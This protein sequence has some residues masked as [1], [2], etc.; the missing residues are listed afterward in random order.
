MTKQRT[1][2]A[3]IV[4][5]DVNFLLKIFDLDGG[6]IHDIHM[7]DDYLPHKTIYMVI[8]HPDLPEVNEVETLH[9]A[10]QTTYGENGVPIKIERVDPPKQNN[11][12]IKI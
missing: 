7:R 8:E 4:E 2:H 6:V 9:I 11:G 1:K 3:G 5:V 12:K 10:Y